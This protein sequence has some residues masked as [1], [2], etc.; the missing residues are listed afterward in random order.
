MTW[1]AISAARL[2][3]VMGECLPDVVDGYARDSVVRGATGGFPTENRKRRP[4]L[5]TKRG[6][7]HQGRGKTRATRVKLMCLT[8]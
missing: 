3:F 8:S 1:Q 2:A 6:R 4:A 5:A 7:L